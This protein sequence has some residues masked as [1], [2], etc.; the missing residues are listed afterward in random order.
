MSQLNVSSNSSNIK[1]QKRARKIIA[2]KLQMLQLLS[3][4]QVPMWTFDDDMVNSSPNEE[5]N[6]QDK[7]CEL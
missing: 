4:F 2:Y 5:V 6:K 7:L 3:L 1:C